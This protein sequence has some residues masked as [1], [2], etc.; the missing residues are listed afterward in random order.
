MEHLTLGFSPCPNDTFIFDQLV[1][2]SPDK[3]GIEYE[4]GLADVEQ[5]NQWAF[6]GKFDVTKLSYSAFL[7]LTDQYELL[8][9]GSALGFG[10]G[11]LL[12]TTR[13][14]YAAIKNDPAD[15]LA[16]AKI[17]IPGKYTTANL[18][19]SLAYPEAKNKTEVLF[20]DIEQGVLSGNY[21]AG[22]II[23]ENRFTYADKGLEKIM[24][25]GAWWEAQFKAA[26][27]L[28]GIVIRKSLSPETKLKVQKQIKASIQNS[29]QQ[30]PTLSE[31][32]KMHAQ[33][34]S[35]EVMRKHINLYVNE[36]SSSLE[37]LGDQAIETLFKQAYA[38][39]LIKE[40]P[41]QFKLSIVN[42]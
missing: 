29:W 8:D 15:F 28:G 37:G 39:G 10:V 32:V 17:A 42:G 25:C 34:M 26:I 4:F 7:H 11:P 22:L 30:Y 36:Y 13:E 35:E 5:L 33:E 14:K 2:E 19:L 9:S 16:D 31:F 27:P 6:E 24:D 23:H 41:E 21:D 38:S 1:H 12:I 18:L 40:M 20:S 3:N